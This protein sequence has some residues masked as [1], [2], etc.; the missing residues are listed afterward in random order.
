MKLL[1]CCRNRSSRAG[2]RCTVVVFR[3]AVAVSEISAKLLQ[4]TMHG[5]TGSCDAKTVSRSTHTRFLISF[6]LNNLPDDTLSV[7]ILS[8]TLI[9][10]TSDP[11]EVSN[12][13]LTC[14]V[15]KTEEPTLPLPLVSHCGGNLGKLQLCHLVNKPPGVNHFCSFL[16]KLSA[17]VCMESFGAKTKGVWLSECTSVFHSLPPFQALKPSTLLGGPCTGWF[18]GQTI[19]FPATSPSSLRP[20]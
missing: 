19:P 10:S 18:L 11:A 7:S 8:L 13:G 1:H 2:L 9:F 4:G 6:Y 17:H 12:T 15:L 20:P 14:H 3:K 5:S 16:W